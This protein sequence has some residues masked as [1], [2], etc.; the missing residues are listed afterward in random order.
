M[1]R[2]SADGQ[3]R[4][5]TWV[6]AAANRTL[7][8]TL[9]DPRQRISDEVLQLRADLDLR[10]TGAALAA[11]EDTE[12]TRSRADSRAVAG[13]K[14]SV[15]LPVGLAR[16]TVGERLGDPDGARRATA[17]PRVPAADTD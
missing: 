2:R 3:L 8:A 7:Q 13:L 10:E 17:E 14:F 6:G 5:W 11:A 1:L 16:A 12:M 15:A 4:W 9:V